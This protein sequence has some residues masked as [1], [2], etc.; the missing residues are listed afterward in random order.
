MAVIVHDENCVF[1]A[2]DL[3]SSDN[4]T[5]TIQL[6]N[7]T[8]RIGGDKWERSD[9]QQSSANEAHCWASH[10]SQMNR[11]FFFVHRFALAKKKNGSK[12]SSLNFDA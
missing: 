2:H 4:Q 8:Q 5:Q 11:K 10:V 12:L 6:P 7:D 1:D 9:T 3:Y